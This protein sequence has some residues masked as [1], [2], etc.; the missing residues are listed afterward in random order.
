MPNTTYFFF[1]VLS[2]S[3]PFPPLSLSVLSL[4][5]LVLSFLFSYVEHRK[6]VFIVAIGFLLL[7][8]LGTF[9]PASPP[10]HL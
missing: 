8:G 2:L 7:A 9:S 1:V 3:I 5:S 10:L 6:F 4:L